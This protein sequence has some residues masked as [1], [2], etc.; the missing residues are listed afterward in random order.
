MLR[1]SSHRSSTRTRTSAAPLAPR[2][3]ALATAAFFTRTPPLSTSATALTH[4]PSTFDLPISVDSSAASTR[5]KACVGGYG[6]DADVLTR[7]I[8]ELEAKPKS[9]G[10]E[11]GGGGRGGRGGYCKP[12]KL[13]PCRRPRL[14]SISFLTLA[15]ATWLERLVTKLIGALADSE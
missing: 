7:E 11:G 9:E 6:T 12:E 13:Y 8:V 5:S 15:S 2:S 14:P 10:P 3:A 4:L 1:V